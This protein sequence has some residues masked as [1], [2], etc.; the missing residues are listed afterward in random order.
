MM[1]AIIS[2]LHSN[3]EALKAV[4]KDIN[5][6]NV[7]EIHCLGDIVNYGPDPNAVIHLLIKHRVKS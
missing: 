1:I 3:E 2:D 4:L 6:F 5:D 7:E